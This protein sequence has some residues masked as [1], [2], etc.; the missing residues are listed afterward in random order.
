MDRENLK[1]VKGT[2]MVKELV[3][4]AVTDPENGTFVTYWFPQLANGEAFP[5]L[6]HTKFFE[7]WGWVIGTGYYIDAISGKT[8]EKTAYIRYMEDLDWYVILIMN[9]QFID[10][11]VNKVRFS[12]LLIAL[13]TKAIR[14]MTIMLQYIS[15]GECDL[16]KLLSIKT[17][18]EIGTMAGYFNNFIENLR[19]TIV[20]IKTVSESSSHLG[21]NLAANP[22]EISATVEEIA[23]TMRSLGDKNKRFTGEIERSDNLITDIQQNIANVSQSIE[24][25]TG[26]ITES[27]AAIEEMVASIKFLTQI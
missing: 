20:R 14:N 23:A 1:D 10:D 26:Y 5:K 17:K 11:T 18:D 22:E 21:H 25:E 7:P 2:K 4:G 3:A 9:E 24:K 6:G 13:I 16:T 8:V 12:I 19:G 27:S 15:E